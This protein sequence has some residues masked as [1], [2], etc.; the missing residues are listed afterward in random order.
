VPREPLAMDDRDVQ[1]V[2]V[3]LAK[4]LDHVEFIRAHFEE[5][6]EEEEADE[7]DDA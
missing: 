7:E 4:I 5:D 1:T 6:D 3:T 2:M